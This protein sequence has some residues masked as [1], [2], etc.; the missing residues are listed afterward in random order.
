MAKTLTDA[1]VKAIRKPSKARVEYADLRSVGL[2]FRV[3]A[4][5]V[6]SWCFRFRDPRSGRSSRIGLGPYPA[7]SLS[8]ARELAEAQR[9]VVAKG[10]NPVEIRRQERVEAPHKT[11]EA[12][13]TRY[14]AEHADRHKRPR[15]AAEDRRNLDLHV[16]PRCVPAAT[17]TFVVPTSSGW[18]RGW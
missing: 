11:F 14:L 17:R 1:F 6:R 15:S 16:L 5:G 12:L 18:S 3:T 9:R 7:V 10:R 13:A 8:A 4:S 2:A